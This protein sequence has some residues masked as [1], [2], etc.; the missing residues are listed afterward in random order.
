M[1]TRL[2]NRPRSRSRPSLRS[3]LHTLPP[4]WE[5]ATPP[6]RTERRRERLH[7]SLHFVV[8]TTSRSITRRRF[9]RRTGEVALGAG[10]A[11]NGWIWRGPT[12]AAHEPLETGCGPLAAG[13]GPSPI[14]PDSQCRLSGG[15]EGKCRL[16]AAGV[17]TRVNTSN[18][19]AGF[20]C[21]TDN[22]HHCW[23]ECCGG[24]NLKRCCD[25][26]VDPANCSGCDACSGCTGKRACICRRTIGTC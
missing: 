10:L 9:L 7:S 4:G 15:A 6:T 13:C 16:G 1:S 3:R 26:C 14:C 5:A 11:L 18:H 8:V 2:D 20:S 12:A 22:A 21:G 17:R 24:N 25:C 23:R 19:W